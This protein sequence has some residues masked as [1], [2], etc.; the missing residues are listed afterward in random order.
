MK[1]NNY[2]CI[3]IPTYVLAVRADETARIYRKLGER[4]NWLAA[5]TA[6]RNA[7]AAAKKARI[8]EDRKAALKRWRNELPSN[9]QFLEARR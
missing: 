4:A 9:V 7:E 8:E 3:Q 1:Q 5:Q 6:Q 2:D